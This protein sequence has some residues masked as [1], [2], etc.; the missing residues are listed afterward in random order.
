MSQIP[1]PK[2]LDLSSGDSAP[3]RGVVIKE[4]AVLIVIKEQVLII[5]AGK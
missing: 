5:T 4:Q 1:L 3:H 2:I